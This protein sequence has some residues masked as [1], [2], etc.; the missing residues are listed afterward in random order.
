M[1]HLHNPMFRSFHALGVPSVCAVYC[2]VCGYDH[3]H[4]VVELYVC[5]DVSWSGAGLVSQPIW[6]DRPSYYSRVVPS[7]HPPVSHE[8]ANKATQRPKHA[9]SSID[10]GVC[11]GVQQPSFGAGSRAV[12]V[13]GAHGQQPLHIAG[14]QHAGEV[15][16]RGSPGCSK[17]AL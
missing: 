11:R 5:V 17:P 2:G 3:D 12:A 15:F 4:K 13:E 10:D 14:L 6:P 16:A 8:L 1:T 7:T 9:R